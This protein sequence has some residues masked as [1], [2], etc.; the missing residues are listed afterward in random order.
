MYLLD[1]NVIS[2]TIAP[3]PAPPVV[4]WFSAVSPDDL[5]VPA[6]AKAE[7]LFGVAVLPK[8]RRRDALAAMI[9]AYLEPYERDAILPF[10]TREAETYAGIVANRRALGRPVREL[11]AQIAAIAR[12]RNLAVVT[13]NVADFD[14]CGVAVIN[15][16]EPAP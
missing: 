1:T 15:P 3:R 4:E 13:R 12:T 14:E 10:T 16:W 8:G 2:E 5:Y 7:L 9:S 6:I 11:D